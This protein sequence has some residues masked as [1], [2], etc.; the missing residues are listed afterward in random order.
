MKVV[1][2]DEDEV[3]YQLARGAEVYISGTLD[4]GEGTVA[5]KRMASPLE[6][7]KLTIG[8]NDAQFTLASK[9][10]G[11]LSD[12]PTVEIEIVEDNP[13]LVIEAN[14]SGIVIKPATDGTTVETLASELVSVINSSDDYSR[15]F[16]ASL[17]SGDG[18]DPIIEAAE[19]PMTQA[20]I[21][22]AEIEGATLSGATDLSVINGGAGDFIQLLADGDG[23]FEY[24]V[25]LTKPKN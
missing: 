24:G 16:I 5:V 4:A 19:A 3:I 21:E 6:P 12:L 10:K 13:E 2:E 9:Q 23:S 1:F 8:T 25:V 17:D 22:W 15:F 7:A 14:W 11:I 18:S 20:A